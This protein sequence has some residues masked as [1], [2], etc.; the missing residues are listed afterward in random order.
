MTSSQSG[1]DVTIEPHPNEARVAVEVEGKPFTTY[2]FG[3]GFAKPVLYPL[4]GP[5]GT[6]VPRGFPIDPQRGERTDHPHH[7]GHWFNYGHVNG[8][9]F[10]NNAGQDPTTESTGQIRHQSIQRAESGDPGV[11]E[12]TADWVNVDGD[13][14]LHEKTCFQFHAP[15][16][17]HIVDR[18][19]RLE[20]TDGAVTLSD[21]KEGMCAIRV[22]KWLEH[23]TDDDIEVVGPNGPIEISGETQRT[24]TY[25]SSEGVR[26]VDV[27]GTRARWMSLAGVVDDEPVSVT[28]FD[29]PTNVGYP[30]FW[31]ARPYGLFAANPFGQAVFTD[32]ETELGYELGADDAIE[33]RYRIAIDSTHPDPQELDERHDAFVERGR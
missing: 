24:G 6:P 32:G 2:R 19:T 31:H 3:E 22:A 20:A 29:H 9:D 10:W 14:Q 30:T 18:T 23:P 11:L 33:F 25:L 21:D 27:W 5:T 12:V 1:P 4:K 26:G 28:M 17:R 16:G 8:L 13:R 7:V 15:D